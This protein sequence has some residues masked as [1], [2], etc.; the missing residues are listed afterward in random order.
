MIAKLIQALAYWPILGLLKLFVRYEVRGQ[1]NLKRLEDKA[2][3][4]ASNHCSYIDGP[5]SAACLPTNGSLFPKNFFPI[6]FPVTEKFFKWTY[7]WYSPISALIV[8]A[9]GCV[10]ITRNGHALRYL[11]EAIGKDYKVWYFPEGGWDDEDMGKPRE[12]K[13]GIG[14]LQI[15][16]GATIVPVG[17]IGNWGILSW[18]T[19]FRIKK[20]TVNIGQPIYTFNF[21]ADVEPGKIAKKVMDKIEQLMEEV[22]DEKVPA[23]ARLQGVQ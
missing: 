14:F 16:T 7:N 3:I 8:R 17:I 15:K 6:R 18:K 21:P 20:V 11:I 9:V 19:L 1:E 10:K 13:P 22:A 4:F 23:K 12:A 5:L 2:I